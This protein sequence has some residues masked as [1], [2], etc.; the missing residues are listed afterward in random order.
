MLGKLIKYEFKATARIFLPLFSALLIVSAITKLLSGASV[1]VPFAISMTLSVMLIIAAFVLTLILT[2]QRF[3]KN[4]MTDEGYLMHTLPV[5]AGRLIL[6]KL[7]AAAVWTL[8]CAAVVFLSLMIMAFSGGELREFAQMLRNTG[9]PTADLILF[10]LEF[11]ALALSGLLGSILMIYASLAL[12]MFFNKHRIGVSFAI[13]IGLTTA[14]QILMGIVGVIFSRM[15]RETYQTFEA[16]IEQNTL[17]SVHI[18]M[19][20]VLAIVIAFAVGMFFTTRTMLKNRLN[21]Q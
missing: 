3:Y 7:I 14:L 20:T 16:F 13:Y 17:A 15:S 4:L 6:A 1:N 2:V 8:V 11:C 12:S 5:G 21:L 10:I 9:L 18:C 19:S